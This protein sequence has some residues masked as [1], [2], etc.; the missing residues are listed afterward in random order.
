MKKNISI[1]AVLLKTLI[2]IVGAYLFFMFGRFLFGNIFGGNTD[3]HVLMIIALIM[4]AIGSF[5]FGWGSSALFNKGK[6]KISQGI[7]SVTVVF[8]A[9]TLTAG[10]WML[11]K[12]SVESMFPAS[13]DA[14]FVCFPP[15][16]LFLVLLGINLLVTFILGQIVFRVIK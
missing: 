5:V 13:C 12:N 16:G 2:A 11:I 7:A 6:F 9:E 10:I 3:A 8:F 14:T 15:L 1:G 4:A